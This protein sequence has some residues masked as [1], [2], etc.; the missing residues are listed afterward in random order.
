MF[1]LLH[2]SERK[3]ISECFS[4]R[5]TYIYIYTYILRERLIR[6]AYKHID[7]F[8]LVLR[9]LDFHII[10]LNITRQDQLQYIYINSNRKLCKISFKCARYWKNV[11]ERI[12][13]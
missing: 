6:K 9:R 1:T 13:K 2:G 11:F 4:R 5:K 12:R 10:S 3:K 7:N 8:Y